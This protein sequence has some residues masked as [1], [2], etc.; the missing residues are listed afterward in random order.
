MFGYVRPDKAELKIKEFNRYRSVYCGLCK[1][2]GRQFG[3]LPRLAVS[4]DMTFFALL[5]QALGPAEPLVTGETCVLHPRRKRPIAQADDVLLFC[6]AA[7]VILAELN[8]E[9]DIADGERAWQS[10][11]AMA[12]LTG[13]FKKAGRTLPDFKAEAKVM[14]TD[15]YRAE[16]ADD[17]TG[18]TV[19]FGHFLSYLFRQGAKQL[20]LT[21]RQVEAMALAGNDLG[22]WIYLIDAVDDRREDARQG[23]KNPLPSLA[24]DLEQ[25]PPEEKDRL[26][27]ERPAQAADLDV[28]ILF[29][30]EQLEASL[31]R[32]LA[33]LP[34]R[35]D[36]NIIGNIAAAG[37]P[38]ARRLVLAGEPPVKL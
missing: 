11:L 33:L 7:T 31:D 20:D 34:Y 35:R 30:L 12:I 24:K 21:E 15:F 36:G 14:M 38:L 3:Q 29:K 26:L 32:T 4:Y 25:P 9:D 19:A 16:A 22:Q 10:R 1:V 18:A 23:S 17:G 5:L 37:I 6:A 2:I 8:L 27:R 13:A 28:R